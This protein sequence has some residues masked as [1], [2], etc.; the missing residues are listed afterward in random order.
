MITI[1]KYAK[2]VCPACRMVDAYLRSESDF[3]AEQN[4]T[5]E[6]IDVMNDLTEDER[7]N[8]PFQSVPFM[9][10]YRN[11]VQMAKSHGLAIPDE[12]RDCVQ[13]AKES[14]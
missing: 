3:I 7:D 14:K 2:E 4:L 12:F 9:L 13:I 6:T 11:G 10:F 5:I 8:L 1:K